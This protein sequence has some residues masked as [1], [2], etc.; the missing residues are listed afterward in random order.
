MLQVVTDVEQNRNMSQLPLN[1]SQTWWRTCVLRI[2]YHKQFK[3]DFTL[4]MKRGFEGRLVRRSLEFSD[5]RKRTSLSDIVTINW[6]IPS[7]SKMFGCHIQPD[8][9]W[10]QSRWGQL[11]LNLLRTGKSQWFVLET[12][13]RENMKLEILQ[14]TNQLKSL[15]LQARSGRPCVAPFPPPCSREQLLLASLCSALKD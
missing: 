3:K 14:K 1:Q 12:K 15:C 10:F 5:S 4:A 7:I 11:I 9:L 6:P 8:W 2:R 13:R